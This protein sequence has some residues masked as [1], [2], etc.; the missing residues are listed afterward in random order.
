[1]AAQ[2]KFGGPPLLRS[3]SLF[4]DL[5]DVEGRQKTILLDTLYAAAI[6]PLLLLAYGSAY[7]IALGARR[8]IDITLLRQVKEIYDL[9]LHTV[10]RR[11]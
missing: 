4:W 11:T 7:Y 9:G 10:S 6:R 2:F 8:Y 3:V 1:M 5:C